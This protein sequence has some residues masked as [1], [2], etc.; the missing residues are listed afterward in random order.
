MEIFYV[1][2]SDCYFK[3][4]FGNVT[5]KTKQ[6]EKDIYNGAGG[7]GGCSEVYEISFATS[8]ISHFSEE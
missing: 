5:N 2:L 8:A 4:Y 3:G 6:Y 1:T 7:S